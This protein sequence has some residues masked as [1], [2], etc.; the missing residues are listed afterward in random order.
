VKLIYH[1]YR[2]YSHYQGDGVSHVESLVDPKLF[3]AIY[4]Y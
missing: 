2:D 3:E 4:V 1:C